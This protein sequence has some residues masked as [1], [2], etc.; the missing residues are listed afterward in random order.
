MKTSR[1]A[2]LLVAGSVAFSA[3]MVAQQA[4]DAEPNNSATAAT[5]VRL[6]DMISGT[7]SYQDVDYFALDILAGTKLV[8]TIVEAHFCPALDLWDRDGTTPLAARNCMG[9]VTPHDTIYYEIRAAGRYYIS[10]YHW[11]ET[12]GDANHPPASYTLRATAYKAPPPGLGNPMRVFASALGIVRGWV[13]TPTGDIIALEAGNT[14]RVVRINQQGHT[15]TFASDV[16]RNWQ[17]AI[18]AFGELLVPAVRVWWYLLGTG[19]STR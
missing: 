15:T 4:T 16:P 11:D 1:V 13:A 14:Q 9:S 12:P 19:Q 5:I 8:L 7:M 3:S 2:G 6:G 17:I 18:D 10:L